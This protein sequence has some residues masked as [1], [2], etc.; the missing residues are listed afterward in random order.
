M[1]TTR[2]VG[3]AD[4]EEDRAVGQRDVGELLGLLDEDRGEPGRDEQ[5]GRDQREQLAVAGAH[6]PASLDLAALERDHEVLGVVAWS[7]ACG[8]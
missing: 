2:W 7:A 4:A 1:R 3:D 8:R 6:V 5:R